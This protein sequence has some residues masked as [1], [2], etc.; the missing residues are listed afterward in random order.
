MHEYFS[1][2]RSTHLS[3]SEK[4]LLF[5]SSSVLPNID[6]WS[7][8]TSTDGKSCSVPVVLRVTMWQ[9]ALVAVSF[10]GLGNGTFPIAE[11]GEGERVWLLFTVAWRYY[12]CRHCGHCR[13]EEEQKNAMEAICSRPRHAGPAEKM[14]DDADAM[15]RHADSTRM[16]CRR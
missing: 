9:T 15:R 11:G 16:P 12:C 10:G 5:T 2:F 13:M 7:A 8:H 3:S 6:S 1:S 4:I 14:K